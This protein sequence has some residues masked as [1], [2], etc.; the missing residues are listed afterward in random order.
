[1]QVLQGMYNKKEPFGNLGNSAALST[2]ELWTRFQKYETLALDDFTDKLMRPIYASL[3]A[4]ISRL[5]AG[6][7]P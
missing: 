4:S 3:A 7:M 5:L 1:M 2:E 6:R